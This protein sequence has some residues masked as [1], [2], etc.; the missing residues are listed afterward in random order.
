MEAAR[1]T[2]LVAIACGGTGGHLFPGLAI[3]EALEQE[4]AETWLL[5]SQKDV[6]QQAV[7]G[8]PPSQVSTLP[9]VGLERGRLLPFARGLWASFTLARR[10]FR[11]R[12]PDVVLAMGGFTSLAP[13][14]AGRRCGAA[15]YLHE[16]N[17]VPG[18][19]NRWLAHV[20]DQAFV[21]FPEAAERLWH[22]QV[23]ALG[24]P[25][26]SQFQP[27]D[28]AA[29]RLALGLRG[30]DPVLLVTGGSQGAVALNDI[31]LR[32]MPAL[33]LLHPSLQVL[34]LTGTLDFERVRREYSAQ[35]HPAVVRPFLTE[36]ELALAA[37]SVM[38]S[39]AGASSLAE[40]AALRVPALLVPLPTAADN[41]Q[42]RNARAFQTS[43]AAR[44]LI[45]EG[46]TPEKVLWELRA[47]LEPGPLRSGIQSALARWHEPHAASRIAHILLGRPD[48]P[49][50]GVEEA[51]PRLRTETGQP[52]V[53]RTPRRSRTVLAVAQGPTA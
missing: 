17:A 13:V 28:A 45:Q 51:V 43:G 2:R 41:H 6:D 50:A 23:K 18:R 30:N 36:M 38:V 20:V 24:M 7:R 5:I 40:T 21:Y 10:L 1:K 19:A 9:A 15:T 49:A 33:R 44:V 39:R 37:A 3:A 34:H 29:A 52:A 31:V 12:V 25:V 53:P 42:Y 35:K 11:D 47:L 48:S 46:A 32:S 8:L 26:R 27:T 16:A 4:G 14:L 22:Q